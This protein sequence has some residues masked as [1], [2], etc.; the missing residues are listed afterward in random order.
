MEQF[1]YT[2]LSYPFLSQGR[3]SLFLALYFLMMFNL[4]FALALEPRN[5]ASIYLAVF[6]EEVSLNSHEKLDQ[7]L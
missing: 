1:K 4:A 7:V 5:T 6:S 2:Y 3:K